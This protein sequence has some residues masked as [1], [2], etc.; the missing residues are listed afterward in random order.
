V[1]TI[2]GIGHSVLLYILSLGIFF[3]GEVKAWTLGLIVITAMLLILS[4]G[5][6]GQARFRIPAEP[7]FSILAGIGYI[8]FRMWSSA[9][10]LESNGLHSIDSL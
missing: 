6:V 5:S 3:R 4:P 8:K 7:Y 2:L 1:L 9:H 10:D